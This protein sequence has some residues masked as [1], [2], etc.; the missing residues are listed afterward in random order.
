MHSPTASPASSRVFR[1]WSVVAVG[2]LALVVTAG[3]RTAPGAFL[4]DMN[5]DTGWSIGLLSAA[6][7][8]GLLVFGFAGP[9]SA[10]LMARFGVRT[11][12]LL[13]LG[14][15]AGSMIASSA[16]R[17][18]WQLALFFGI[19]SGLGT[20]LVASI[21][22]ATIANRWF[23]R[24][25]GL[26]IGILGASGSAGQLIFFPFLTLLADAIGWRGAAVVFAALVA[27]CVLPVVLLLRDD[28]ADLGLRP[29]GGTGPVA[30][31]SPP[32]PGVMRRA[33]RTSDFWLLAGTFFICG[34][35]SNG[36]I[37]QHFIAHAAD[38]G[39]GRVEASAALA[40]MGA[41]NFVGTI[42]SG[43][44]TDR[45]DPRKLL[46]AYYGFRGLS[47]LYL[48]LI[49]D[50]L[51]VTAFAI[52]FGLDYIATVPPT[53]AL[54]ADTFG[55]R[56]VGVVYGWV[57]AS[58]MIGAAVAA[59]GAGIVRDVIG[60]YGPALVLAGWTAVAAGVAAMGIR[61]RPVPVPVTVTLDPVG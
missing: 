5:D 36:L 40:V 38:H 3:A 59:A 11:V 16:V 4:L 42:V 24:K 31:P 27:A 51:D 57:F 17:E 60:D 48:P 56:N 61:R 47:L 25:R 43:W 9:V 46:L 45:W 41:F 37:G 49:H 15:T 39:F 33:V 18:V 13:S 58:H 23:V 32:E 35:T 26:V 8:L 7:S 54:A 44:L 1:G 52:L 55:R 21:L 34:A 20:G 14:L 12:T 28:P 2:A 29:H 30:P 10:A 19:V 6:A 22:G 53:I 50:S